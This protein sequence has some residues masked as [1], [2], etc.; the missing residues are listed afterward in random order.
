MGFDFGGG[1]GAEFPGAFAVIPADGAHHAN[2]DFGFAFG[3]S[4]S[5][6]GSITAEEA[7]EFRISHL[8]VT[9]D[10]PIFSAGVK[11]ERAFK[12]FEKLH[13][14]TS[15]SRFDFG[16]TLGVDTRHIKD[17]IARWEDGGDVVR[18]GGGCATGEDQ[19]GED[20][21]GED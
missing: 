6:E 8:V 3:T 14:H 18:R 10:D 12:G 19:T 20:C 7:F 21:N 9:D 13:P 2:P 4:V 1:G 16:H 17:G 15:G 5:D 11:F